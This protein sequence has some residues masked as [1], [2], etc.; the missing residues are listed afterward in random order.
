MY[1]FQLFKKE[2]QS[3][4]YKILYIGGGLFFII[5]GVLQLLWQD[6]FAL[7]ARLF[8]Y[9]LYILLGIFWILH[10]LNVINVLARNEVKI[11]TDK[12]Y[13][14]PSALEKSTTVYWKTIEKIE[15]KPSKLLLHTCFDVQEIGLGWVPYIDLKALKEELESMAAEKNIPCTKDSGAL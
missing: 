7:D 2:R 11:D 10:G 8:I 6:E 1:H 9:L 5:T 15:I 4:G 12:L 13:V 3:T 14:N